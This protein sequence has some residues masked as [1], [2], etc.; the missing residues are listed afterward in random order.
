MAIV[1]PDRSQRQR[2]GHR[3][4]RWSCRRVL[5]RRRDAG[6]PAVIDALG[7]RLDSGRATPRLPTPWCAGSAS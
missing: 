7:R 3:A 2:P 5:L 1:A 4:A 6:P